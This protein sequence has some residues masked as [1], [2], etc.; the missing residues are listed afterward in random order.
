MTVCFKGVVCLSLKSTV[1]RCE[2]VLLVIIFERNL[3]SSV[4]VPFCCRQ[5]RASHYTSRTSCHKDDVS[6][7]SLIVYFVF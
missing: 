4:K 1:V 6:S 2:G 7:L 3:Q 5:L